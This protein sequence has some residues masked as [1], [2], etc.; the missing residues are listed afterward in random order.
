MPKKPHVN[1]GKMYKPKVG[2]RPALKWSSKFGFEINAQ[3]NNYMSRS[4]IKQI[5]WPER[6]VWSES[7]LS[8]QSL[9]CLHE[10]T[11]GP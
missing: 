10:E 6:P 8:D 2:G 4:T 3:E 5:K 1:F 11:L 9:R 7:S